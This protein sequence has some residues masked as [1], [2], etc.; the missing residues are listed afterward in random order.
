M[1]TTVIRQTIKKKNQSL[2]T[3]NDRVL[4]Y[5]NQ[6]VAKLQG[7]VRNSGLYWEM[8]T[9]PYQNRDSAGQ[10]KEINVLEI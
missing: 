8:L 10:K 7:E 2:N 1:K 6:E 5:K 4:K 9:C 3:G